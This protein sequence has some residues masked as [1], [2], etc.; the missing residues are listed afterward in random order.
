MLYRHGELE[1]ETISVI[2]QNTM[3]DIEVCRTIH[4]LQ[5][6]KYLIWVVHNHDLSKVILS[7]FE[8][9]E[10]EIHSTLEKYELFFVQNQQC[11]FG[12][13]HCDE[14]PIFMYLPIDITKKQEQNKLAVQ[15]VEAC[16]STSIPIP[17]LRCILEQDKINLAKDKTVFFSMQ[18]DLESLDINSTEK[19]CVELCINILLDMELTYKKKN[20]I[21]EELLMKRLT[22]KDYNRFQELYR[23]V[24]VA[25]EV[26]G[27]RNWKQE[28]IDLFLKYKDKLFKTLLILGVVTSV[29]GIITLISFLI[30]GDIPLLRIL[31]NDFREIGTVILG[32]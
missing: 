9:R 16:M 25:T 1:L 24:Q 14:R 5:E 20:K 27:K 17:V 30:F 31:T 3:Q 6:E 15:L 29:L 18:V 4:T 22:N 21:L 26:Q 32:P 13:K 2:Q 23:D 19:Q 8:N 28:F 12:F 11:I 7:M 10:E